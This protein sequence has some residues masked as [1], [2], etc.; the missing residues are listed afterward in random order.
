MRLT[1]DAR[2]LD[3]YV[4]AVIHDIQDKSSV[5]LA[6]VIPLT[7]VQIV[8]ERLDGRPGF[9]EQPKGRL[10]E[11]RK[12]AGD[13]SG[14]DNEHKGCHMFGIRGEVYDPSSR[15]GK[16]SL[17]GIDG[18]VPIQMSGAFQGEHSRSQ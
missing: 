8:L 16:E 11:Q 10:F 14:F 6:R 2:D 3:R 18:F 5:R 15:V 9:G 7:K 4:R 1:G 13:V 17:G 12:E